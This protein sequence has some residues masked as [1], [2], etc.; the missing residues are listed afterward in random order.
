MKRIILIAIAVLMVLTSFVAC[1][2][3]TDVYKI[4]KSYDSR[5]SAFYGHISKNQYFWF[6]MDLTQNDET[7]NFVQATNGNN[8]TTIL[9]YEGTARDSYQI[10]TKGTNAA[11]VHTLHI[12]D[13]KYDTDIT[14]SFQDF[15]FGGEDPNAFSEPNWTGDADFEG[16]TY[17]CEQ[18]EVAS[19]E[20]SGVDGYNNYYYSE[21]RLV[22]VEILQ[23][24]K[25]T[26][27]MKFKEY[28]IEVPDYIYL[29]PPSDYK[30]GTFRVES[31]IDYGSMGWD[32]E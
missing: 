3:E 19:G 18:F 13:Q 26:M 24:D 25:V 21:G 1:N 28:G 6:D 16:T 27:T 23:N 2:K 20:G 4:D 14:E 22:A 29:T 9:D 5:T 12:A 8:V 30:K 10:A 11:V 32:M 31:V 7:Y 15:L 17:Y